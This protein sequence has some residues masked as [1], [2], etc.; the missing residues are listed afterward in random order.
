MKKGIYIL[1]SL[2]LSAPIWAQDEVTF[3]VEKPYDMSEELYG[4]EDQVCLVSLLNHQL[5]LVLC[6]SNQSNVTTSAIHKISKVVVPKG[7]HLVNLEVYY[8]DY[9]KAHSQATIFIASE[10]DLSVQFY[11]RLR[12]AFAGDYIEFE[13]ILIEKENGERFKN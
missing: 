7:S 6:S 9:F 8:Y 11:L 13:N 12:N 4:P 1:L 10:G 3:V 5:E 2:A